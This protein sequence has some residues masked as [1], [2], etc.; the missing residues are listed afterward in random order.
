MVW[1]LPA[2]KQVHWIFAKDHG[3]NDSDY[4]SESDD[5]TLFDSLS[6]DDEIESEFYSMNPKD[7]GETSL[8]YFLVEYFKLVSEQGNDWKIGFYCPDDWNSELWLHS[9]DIEEF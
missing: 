5:S 3:L 2:K 1:S 9:L 8:N 6:S 7:P 4:E